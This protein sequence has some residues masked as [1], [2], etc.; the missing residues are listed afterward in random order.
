MVFNRTAR[1]HRFSFDNDVCVRCGMSRA[2]HERGGLPQCK[3]EPPEKK[4]RS[5][6]PDDDPRSSVSQWARPAGSKA[7][8]DGRRAR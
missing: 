1:G 6:I 5:S 4:E 7:G 2:K 8:A 3:G